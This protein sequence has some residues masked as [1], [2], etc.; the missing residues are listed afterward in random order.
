ML[1]PQF[2][3]FSY[4]II[5]VCYFVSI[6]SIFMIRQLLLYYII[7]NYPRFAQMCHY[8]PNGSMPFQVIEYLNTII[9]LNREQRT[10][11][12][13]QPQ[14]I[15]F[16]TCLIMCFRDMTCYEIIL[17]KLKLKKKNPVESSPKSCYIAFANITTS[18]QGTV[19]SRL[20]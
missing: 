8:V 11:T 6:L 13:F 15:R 7:L 2:I 12:K 20:V 1:V 10:H 5:I 14:V 17:D 4:T 19:V 16:H 3:G 18:Q 9:H